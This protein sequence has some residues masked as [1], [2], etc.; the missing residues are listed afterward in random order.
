MKVKITLFLILFSIC[1]LADESPP[2]EIV[3]FVEFELS[4]TETTDLN[5]IS[6]PLTTDFTMASELGDAIEGCNTVSRWNASNQSWDTASY[7][8]SLGWGGDFLLESGQAY[9]IN[10]TQ[11]SEYSF[12]GSLFPA[13]SYNLVTTIGTNLNTIMVPMNRSDL[14]LASEL[15]EDIG[16]CE[17]ISE[18][19]VDNQ[20]WNT[21]SDLGFM[22]G[23]NFP[24]E[25]SYP[26]IINVTTDIVWPAAGRNSLTKG[27]VLK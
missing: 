22:W 16:V 7:V 10:V 4:Q 15:G 23:N 1:L 19:L 17:G 12:A 8:P 26:L 21:A 13:P 24:I 25:I 11:D 27:E 3:G 18:W 20:Q 2:S 5:F 9:M 6:I 14:Q